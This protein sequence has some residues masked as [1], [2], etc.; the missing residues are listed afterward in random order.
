MALNKKRKLDMSDND[1]SKRFKMPAKGDGDVMEFRTQQETRP[2]IRK[3]VPPRPYP[4]VP[5]SVSA[6][7]PRSAHKEGKNI[8]CITRKTPLAAYLRRCTALV[9]EGC[10]SRWPPTVCLHWTQLQ[11]TLLFC[12]GRGNPAFAAAGLRSTRYF[13]L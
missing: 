5:P 6:T 10:V 7:G 11:H 13:A 9:N 4:T 2:K 8:I 12:D 3:L 1:A